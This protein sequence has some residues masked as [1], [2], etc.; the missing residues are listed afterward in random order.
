MLA[1][2]ATTFTLCTTLLAN[3]IIY[4]L[5]VIV[6][7]VGIVIFLLLLATVT[8]NRQIAATHQKYKYCLYF[9]DLGHKA[10]LYIF[11]QDDRQD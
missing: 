6:L 9:K 10:D 7:E 4:Q 1:L 3:T 11:N 5:E 2:V 8:Q